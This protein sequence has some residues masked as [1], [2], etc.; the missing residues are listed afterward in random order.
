MTTKTTGAAAKAARQARVSGASGVNGVRD[1]EPTTEQTIEQ[2]NTEQTDLAALV[3]ARRALD[4]RIKAVR[5][6]APRQSALDALIARQ[7]A[8]LTLW[9]PR[10]L[11][12]RVLARVRAG[13]A[14]DEAL[15]QV[16]SVFRCA[17]TE[18]VAR[19]IAAD[20]EAE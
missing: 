1:D 10:G 3:A 11:T 4:E 14:V 20:S 15:E 18:A 13:Q 5:A 7:D 17:V 12:Q 6:A 16:F 8:N 9:L 19:A 2:V